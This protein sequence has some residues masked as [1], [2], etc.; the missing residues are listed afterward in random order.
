MARIVMGNRD[1]ALALAQAR[2]VLSD[3]AAEWPDVHLVQRTIRA[4]G[5]EGEFQSLFSALEK[6]SVNIALV[7]LERLPVTLPDGLSLAAVTKRLEPRS[8]LVSKGVRS[9]AELRGGSVVGVPSERD[10]QFLTSAGHDFQVELLTGSIDH[11]LGLLASG[12]LDALILPCSTM[13]SL[14]RRDRVEALLEPEAFVPA[15]GQGSLGLIVRAD[16]DLAFE[17][18]YT[19]QHRPSFD[20]VA[21]ERSFQQSLASERLAVGA[22]ATVAPDGE[23]TLLGAVAAPEGP[24]LQGTV[25]GEAGEAEEL[26]RELAQDVLEQLKT[27]K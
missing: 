5:G 17:I 19:L 15:V 26:G 12:D 3:L 14:D 23:L 18:A 4:Q 8:A 24:V 22:L 27:F 20:R 21:A 7:G 9:M 11:D 13:L 16:D 25:N 6:G 1:G 2:A 10:K